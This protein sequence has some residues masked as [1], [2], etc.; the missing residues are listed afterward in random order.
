MAERTLSALG[1]A[2]L[3]AAGCG[4]PVFPLVPSAKRPATRAG[5]KDASQAAERIE[6]W[7]TQ[8]PGAN[9]GMPT[10]QASGRFVVDVD[11]EQGAAS[12]A[13][14]EAAHG[15]L[16]GGPRVQT[17]RGVHIHFACPNGALR[18][19][20]GR[21]GAGL[22]TRS[23]GGYVVLPP[24]T[25]AAGA[26]EWQDPELPLP[27]VPEWLL[28]LLRAPAP[29][30]GN[31]APR[32][33]GTANGNAPADAAP[34]IAGQRNARLAS[35]AGGLRRKG[36][37]LDELTAALAEANAA[38]CRPPLP[39]DEL[40]RIAQSIMR[41]EPAVDKKGK[42]L[43][44]ALPDGQDREGL[45]AWLGA[46]LRFAADHPATGV[47]RTGNSGGAA[48]LEVQRKAAPSVVFEPAATVD[49][50]G[51]LAT[52]LAWSSTVGDGVAPTL[53]P[54]QCQM[55]GWCLRA[56]CDLAAT[57]TADEEAHGVIA[58]LLG[59]AEL[60]EGHTILGDAQQ[61]YAAVLALRGSSE[62][63]YDRPEWD[64]GRVLVDR[65]TGL[66]VARLSDL[67]SAAR[68]VHG[69]AVPRGFVEGRLAAIGWRRVVLE[70]HKAPGRAGRAGPRAAAVTM[71][72]PST[73]VTK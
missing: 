47:L 51:R 9:I 52:A 34:I 44:A 46:T 59:A 35:L 17:P 26:Y 41:Y 28:E 21:L 53:S 2:A 69:G 27:E 36:A 48:R 1:A 23:T 64:P 67:Q 57:T 38:R 6:E 54:P 11:G 58:D 43:L 61:R 42:P 5:F 56:L 29:A 70:G 49:V 4:V 63:R 12:L 66:V 3:E 8:A 19:T 24:S 13:A 50:P 62:A 20:A 14:L 18:N 25:T 37:T 40:H 31:G 39:D 60:V 45:L 16:P 33:N 15:A 10:G 30:N 68:R 73:P 22:D 65:E 7:W 55:V 32:T 71:V 72:G